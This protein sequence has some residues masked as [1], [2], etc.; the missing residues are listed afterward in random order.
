[1]TCIHN[2]STT[3][4]EARDKFL[5]ACGHT[6][7]RLT[8]Y[9]H[10]QQG[11]GGEALATDVAWLGPAKAERA[12]VVISATHGVEGFCGSGVQCGLLLESDAP[13][14]PADTAL[15]LIHAINP[16]GFAWLSRV[17]E[18]NVDLNRNFVD[19][20][21]ELPENTGYRA[22]ADALVPRH[23][24]ERSLTT[25]QA[26]LD[27]YADKHGLFGL[28]T[29][30][31]SGQYSHPNGVFYGG[32]R[33]TWSR[34]IVEQIVREHL[35]IVQHVAVIDLHTGLG[36]YGYGEP[37]CLN[38]DAAMLARTR[39][40]FGADVTSPVVNDSVSAPL[41]GHLGLG[42]VASAPQKQW[43]I[44]GL[45]FGTLPLEDFLLALRADA[46]L[47][48][49]G[50]P[51]DEHTRTVKRQIRNAFYSDEPEWKRKVWERAREMV[52]RAYKGLALC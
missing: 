27:A 3:Y 41:I 52:T 21:R 31:S 35:P 9:G 43:T 7:A 39:A 48:A 34:C 14:Q 23:W 32:N 44:I 4:R 10:P 5:T 29:A 17:T 37:I 28:Q 2:F 47:R 11:P 18:D 12:L 20:D 49:H 25:A 50:D 8:S 13:E 19:F 26:T 42:L 6:G 40:W 33:P 36:P 30:V 45:E 24:E 22:L 1:M 16:H 38:D 46:W 15:L 51:N